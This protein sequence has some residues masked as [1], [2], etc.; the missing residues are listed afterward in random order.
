MAFVGRTRLHARRIC[1][2][3][4][5]W[6]GGDSRVIEVDD[7]DADRLEMPWCSRCKPVQS[8]PESQ[9]DSRG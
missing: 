9:E 2:E 8:V 4:F 6:R 1:A 7:L 3:G 5:Q